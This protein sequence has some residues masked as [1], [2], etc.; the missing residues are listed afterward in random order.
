MEI[1]PLMT[2]EAEKNL[3]KIVVRP[4]ALSVQVAYR[5]NCR[6]RAEE[7]EAVMPGFIPGIHVLLDARHWRRGWPGQARP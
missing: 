4:F 7:A 1:C 2:T 6:A 3:D 5:P